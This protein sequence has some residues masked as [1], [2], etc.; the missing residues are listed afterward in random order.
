MRKITVI[1]IIS[2][3]TFSC[4]N[5]KKSDHQKTR[6]DF[7]QTFSDYKE[8]ATLEE[9]QKISDTSFVKNGIEPTH[10]IT[11]LKNDTETLILF[12]KIAL[13]KEYKETL[14]ILDTLKIIDLKSNTFITIG[15]CEK[16]NMLPEEIIAIVEKTEKDTIDKVMKA[17]HANTSKQKIEEIKDLKNLLCL[18]ES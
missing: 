13:D 12:C 10:R 11:Q 2:V 18:N 3:L 5:S 1:L 17:W 6:D 14:S 15:Y 9:Y 4:E 7:D 16:N 8:L